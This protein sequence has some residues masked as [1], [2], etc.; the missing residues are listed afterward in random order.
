MSFVAY[1]IPF[2]SYFANC[3]PLNLLINFCLV[4]YEVTIVT[5]DKQNAGTNHNC[6][7][8]FIDETGNRSKEI[9]IENKPKQKFFSRGEANTIKAV[10]KP[11]GGL[12]TL[13]VGHRYRKG[14]TLKKSA[15]DERWHLHEVIVTDL[16]TEDKYVML[17]IIIAFVMILE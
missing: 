12:K 15:D 14:A 13:I 4:A 11:L 2:F 5:S 10:A 8:V 3:R 6:W 9:L 16:E 17:W 1:L 7:L